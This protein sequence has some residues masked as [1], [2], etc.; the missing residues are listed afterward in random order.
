MFVTD[1]IIDERRK[2]RL[3]LKAN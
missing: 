1:F 2:R 3:Q